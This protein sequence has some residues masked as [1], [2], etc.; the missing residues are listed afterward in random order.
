MA[1]LDLWDYVRASGD[2]RLRR[3][4]YV[5]SGMGILER[6]RKSAGYWAPHLENNRRG[7]LRI[8]EKLGPQRGGTLLI[9]GAGRLLDIPWEQLFPLFERVVLHDAD[10]C[11][12]PYVERVMSAARAPMP[13]PLFDIGD[14]TAS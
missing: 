8:A 4:G 6:Y 5:S 10:F 7:L 13:K 11:V 9:L 12:V 3:Q 14:V 1:L 2:R